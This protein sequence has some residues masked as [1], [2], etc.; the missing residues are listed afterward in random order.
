MYTE[1]EVTIM[2]KIEQKLIEMSS[3]SR[4]ENLKND[5]KLLRYQYEDYCESKSPELV[6]DMLCLLLDSFNKVSNVQIE[7]NAINESKFKSPVS[8]SFYKYMVNN[9][10]SPKTANDYVKRVN[11]VC[12][13]EKLL[14]TDVQPFI[15]EY[16]I[17][18]KVDDNKR[19]H[20]APSCALKKFNEFKKVNC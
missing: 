12:D 6:E 16:T 5:I 19:L 10:L 20:N 2:N 14:N 9:G 7:V 3:D 18:D 17:G 11:Q 1:L 8:L 15:D 4:F 13:I